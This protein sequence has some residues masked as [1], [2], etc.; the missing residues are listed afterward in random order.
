M[1]VDMHMHVVPGVDD[2]STDIAMSLQ[3]LGCAYEQ[4]VRD[5]FCTS[6]NAYEVEATE[7]YKARFM[8]LQ[9][10]A[11][12]RFPDLSLHMGCEL[13]CAGEYMDDILYGLEEGV[14]LPLG[15][16][17]CVLTELY[18]DTTP[19]EAKAVV[20]ALCGA[21]WTPILAH[22]ERYSGLFDGQTIEALIGMGAKIQVNLHSLEEETFDSIKQN[23]RYLVDNQWA[24]FVGSDA[25]R[26]NRR[27]PEYEAGVRYLKENC[28]Q[29]YVE[30]LCFKNAGELILKT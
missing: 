1:I 6:H 18:P 17:K 19:E 9:M 5:I 11:K 7:R 21:G 12:S 10:M 4:G 14:F 13:L 24:H 26:I 2:G 22:V 30:K 8:T 25:H 27:A 29:D 15:N 16:S 20:S 28:P 3:M 23:A